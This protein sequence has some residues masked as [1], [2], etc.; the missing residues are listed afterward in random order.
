VVSGENSE[1]LNAAELYEYDY[2][3]YYTTGAANVT[4]GG[5]KQ[6][7]SA[8]YKLTAAAESHAYYTT[9][10]GEQALTS[11]LT[12][13]LKAQNIDAQPLDLLTGTIPEDCD[14]L[15]ISDPASDFAAD[16]LVDEIAQLQTYLENGGKVLLTTSGY[17]ETPNLD[18]VMAQFGLARE[19]GLVVEGDAGHALY[20][21]PYSLFPDYAAAD[22]STALDGVNQ[23]THV[24]LSVAQGITITGT[25]DVTAEPLLYTTEDAYSKQDFDASSSS[26]QEAGDTDG[27]F[28]LAVWARNE[29]TGAEV[30]WIG[31]PNMDNEQVY[32]SIPGNL[33]FLQGCAA[34]LVGQSLLIDTKA[35]EAAPITVPASASMTLGMVFVFGY[36]ALSAVLRGVGD[37]RTPLLII[38]VATV[39]NTVLDLWFVAGLGMGTAGAALATTAA[40]AVSFGMALVLVARRT[41]LLQLKLS[42]FRMHGALLRLILRLGIPS[43]LQMTIAGFSWLVVTFL[44]N[45]YGVDVSAGNGVAIKIKDICQLFISAMASGATTMIAQNLGASKFERAKDVM[46]TAMKITCAMAAAMIVLVELFA[47][48]MAA[49]F[50]NE[51]AVRDAAVLNLRIEI[52][53]QIFY[54]VFMVYHALAIGAGHSTFAMLSSFANCI[55][56]RVVLSLLFNHLWGIYGLYAACAVAP[57]ISVPLG[58][59]YTRSGVWRRSLA[60][61][62]K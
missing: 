61:T 28:S 46:Y 58:W 2:S 49:V 33:T 45:Q 5:E 56:F 36:N 19:P 6:I 30:I 31:C 13:A 14:L 8:I 50:T 40:Q 53:G 3:D 15:I 55:V 27:P 22:E 18:A 1:V 48:Q 57:S 17:T 11:S 29:S 59:L 54:A 39:V 25:D 37:S 47:P 41:G 34:S 35:L 16:G 10:H 24:M 32:Q 20:G 52:L 43:A 9:N 26:A 42:F 38:G 62:E 21:Y 51:A 7:S 44:V 12:K 60:K 23:S 4:F